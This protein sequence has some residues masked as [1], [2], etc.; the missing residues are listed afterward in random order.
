M[1][2]TREKN[3]THFQ[4]RD[5][6]HILQVHLLHLQVNTVE[7]NIRDLMIRYNRIENLKLIKFTMKDKENM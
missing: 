2:S 7:I 5:Q 6:N 3:L 1:I 4:S